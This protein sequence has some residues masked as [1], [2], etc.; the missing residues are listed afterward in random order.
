MICERHNAIA[1]HQEYGRGYCARCFRE[2]LKVAED[3]TLE[4][5]VRRLRGTK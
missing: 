5:L 3:M 1:T 2:A 4:A